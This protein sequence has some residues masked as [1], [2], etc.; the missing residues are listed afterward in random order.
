M[1]LLAQLFRLSDQPIY[2]G[3][4]GPPWCPPA[5][6]VSASRQRGGA[7]RRGHLQLATPGVG[8]AARRRSVAQR[9]QRARPQLPK[10]L[11][12]LGAVGKEREPRL[13]IP[14]DHD[15]AA[16]DLVIHPVRGDAQRLGELWH[17]QIPRDPAWV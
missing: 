15:R 7:V 4:W 12:R 11:Q 10:R 3:S 5:T 9:A 6:P 1:L 14:L 13:R 17:R 8:P 16:L 2:A